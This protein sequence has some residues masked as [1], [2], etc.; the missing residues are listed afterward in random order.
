MGKINN[1]LESNNTKIA[2]YINIGAFILSFVSQ[3]FF[4]I[5]FFN[6]VVYIFKCIQ[7]E[8]AVLL[9][10]L[11]IKVVW[12]Y[13][14]SCLKKYNSFTILTIS[15]IC[16]Y[17]VIEVYPN[18]RSLVFSRY[19]YFN[20]Q[21]YKYKF[22]STPLTAGMKAFERGDY[23]EAKTKFQEALQLL[24]N[25]KYTNDLED[26]IEMIEKNFRI[27]EELG[28]I[29]KDKPIS[30]DKYIALIYCKHLTNSQYYI[31]LVNKCKNEISVAISNYSL[32][33]NAC[34]NN[35][36]DSC[37]I[38]YQHYKWCYFEKDQINELQHNDSLIYE[39]VKKIVLSEKEERTKERLIN[40]WLLNRK[41]L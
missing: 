33:Y 34:I 11:L 16:L 22:Q 3:D 35:N 5:H 14:N 28:D 19:Y 13:L 25:S 20:N 12:P 18:I 8:L 1:F 41:N 31:E 21:L 37:N 9:F 10:F 38:Y 30:L 26:N 23:M 29:Y 2:L 27:A 17:T 7:Y 39:K 15:C 36:I 4:S 6:T 40:T 24:P 32:L